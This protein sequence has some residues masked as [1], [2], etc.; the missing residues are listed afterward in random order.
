MRPL[1]ALAWTT[2]SLL[3]PATGG[4]GLRDARSLP[5]PLLDPRPIASWTFD[6]RS[7]L[8]GLARND[9]PSLAGETTWEAD[10]AALG[11][12]EPEGGTPPLTVHPDVGEARLPTQELSVEAWVRVDEG[13]PWSAMVSA[14]QDNGS[15]ER[16]W[17]LGLDGTGTRF[18]FGL[19]TADAGR[20]T[21]L[22]PPEPLALG[23]WHHVVGV[24]G[25]G[26]QRLYVDGR[27]AA[28]ATEQG[29]EIRYAEDGPVVLG[30]YQDADEVHVLAGALARVALFDEPLTG[31]EVLRRFEA[32]RDDYP[33][34]EGAGPWSMDH[35]V[36]SWLAMRGNNGRTG[37][38]DVELPRE[39]ER[40][41]TFRSAPPSPAWPPPA[42]K[43]YWQQLDRIEP[44][45]VD[46]QALH[47]VLTR[48][49]VLVGSSADDSV[50]CL[51]PETGALRWR[52]TTGGPVRYAPAVEGER[53]LIAS[54]DGRL[55]CVH[56]EDG[57][58]LWSRS[59]GP[60]RDAIPG[61]GRLI[62]PFPLRSGVLVEE[63]VAYTCAGLF[64]SQGVFAAA[65]DVATGEPLWTRDLGERS[66]QG[67]L[68]TADGLL[69]V[70]A[71]RGNPFSLRLD[72]GEDGPAFES[73]GG[74]FAVV[75]DD[76]L[77]AGPGN[78]NSLI[79]SQAGSGRRLVSFQGE[80]LVVTPRVSY[81]STRE[82]IA[83]VDRAQGN[84]LRA[85]LAEVD[86]RLRAGDPAG[87]ELRKRRHALELELADT[88][89]WR[90][91]S[92]RVLT[93][94][95]SPD[96][97]LVGLDGALEAR[98]AR[99]GKLL[100][101]VEVE[102]EVRSIGVTDGLVVAT[103]DQGEVIA[104][105]GS[106]GSAAAAVTAALPSAP[107]PVRTQVRGWFE[108][109]D[110]DRGVALLVEP[111]REQLAA[112]LEQEGFHLAVVHEASD[113][114]DATRELLHTWRLHGGR[115]SVHRAR[116]GRLPLTDHLANVLADPTARLAPAELL[117]VAAPGRSVVLRGEERT[118]PAPLEGAGSWTHQFANLSNTANGG[119]A[120]TT[121]EL[122]LQW[123]GGPGPRRMADR[124]MR[125]APPLVAGGRTFMLGENRVIAVDSYNGT[126]LWDT[127]LPEA[128]RYAMPYDAGYI[129]CRDDVVVAAVDGELWTL[130]A[131]T[132]AVTHRRELPRDLPGK[133]EREA[134]WGYVGVDGDTLYAS[135]LLPSAPRTV[136]GRH[137][138]DE[139]YRSVRPIVTSRALFRTSLE[140]EGT[141]WV[142]ARGAILNPT[143]TVHGGRVCFLEARG[144]RSREHEV[145]RVP[146]P[147]LL[148]DDAWLVA[149]DAGSGE[150]LW[151]RQLDL[152]ACRNIV[153]LCG[154]GDR[155]VLV[156]SGDAGNQDASYLVA[157]LDAG[158]GEE[159]WRAEHPNQKPGELYHGEQVH[160]PVV[161]GD[162]LVAEPFLYDLATGERVVPAGESASWSIR[163]PGHSCGT[164]S[165]S[166]ECL[167]F[168]AG[169]PTVLDVSA[170]ATRRFQ[171]LSPSRVGCW[172]NILPADGLVLIPEAS[173]SCV[174]SYALQTSMAFRPLR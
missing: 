76:K 43:S 120:R 64:P 170:G 56:L 165:G 121:S 69:I 2:A 168:R 174:C 17:M 90:V 172:I 104:L 112:A 39:L 86:L 73:G 149:L 29:G 153:Y 87:D 162:L 155:L 152:S 22:T 5:E 148:A 50:V 33:A 59:I 24:Y 40:A 126:E 114:V 7:R 34:L 96:H 173:S 74:T 65:L 19:S 8:E 20:L 53:V 147:E 1:L 71:G 105:R 4:E 134:H 16:G 127:L 145:G 10:P 42:A 28:A 110:T 85:E 15:F 21:Y 32:H 84:R 94:A 159:L 113:A 133:L 167:F 81:L 103:T 101:R 122:R 161:L 37:F 97:L 107:E 27:L 166:G 141:D 156:G 13:R 12:T 138:A 160:H 82:G 163:R 98:R 72:S 154:A 63:G 46:D 102:G 75:E 136:P 83:A 108:A 146:L 158:T 99:S 36:D 164:M 142:H 31:E 62:S 130:D 66:P 109:A 55:H 51:D 58:L 25:D 116:D 129:A 157:A 48:A 93:L 118:H 115:A 132:G 171:A 6:G 100:Q 11:I 128:Q 3:A 125:T 89:L 41:W 30:A 49:G 131:H 26:S 45:V 9:A 119:D 88:L 68:L 60:E 80:H 151:E 18:N 70:P 135:A 137:I 47:P 57:R 169:N 123:F 44:R 77:I 117:R 78:D 143:I 91:D 111:T 14:I 150:V 140:G 38:A 54:D 124:H 92:G 79:G 144:E 61:N 139:T 67:Y 35:G 95:A 52:Y 23:S 106:A